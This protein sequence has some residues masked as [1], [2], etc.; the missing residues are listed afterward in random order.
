MKVAVVTGASGFVGRAVVSELLQQEVEVFSIVH[1]ETLVPSEL[2]GSHIIACDMRNYDTLPNRI[3]EYSPDVYF[4]FAWEGSAGL[5]RGNEKV[6]LA[7]VQGT[8]NAVLAAVAMGC[9][10]FVFAS[11]IMEYEVDKEIKSMGNP[12]VNSIYSVAKISADYM[13]RILSS[14]LGI[15]YISS[16]IS[17]IYGPGENSPRLINCCIRKL[18][19]GE[20]VSLTS[21]TQL[22]D[23]IYITDAAKMFTAIG[24][25]GVAGSIYYIGNRKVRPLRSFLE[26]LRDVISPDARLGFGELPFSG[27]SLTYNEFDKELLYQHTGIEPQVSF[28]EGIVKTRDWIVRDNRNYE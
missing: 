17:N 27:V 8:C 21:G 13:A 1:S 7:N 23:F 14:N 10:K 4:H 2:I 28:L 5:L 20:H 15:D 19:K 24:Y 22:Y 16:L 18:L 11:S 3:K 25:N 6:Q 9:K 26:E 12:G